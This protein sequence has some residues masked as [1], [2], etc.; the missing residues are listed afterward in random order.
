MQSLLDLGI[1]LL[2]CAV[3]SLIS[4]RLRL[5]TLSG[6][7]MSFLIGV[8]IGYFGSINWLIILIAFALSGFVVTKFKFEL[9]KKK[10]VQEG[11]KGERT[12][13]NVVA[14]S[15][16]P[17]LIAVG[18]WLLGQQGSAA[19]NL[20]YL[21]SVSV[22]ASDTIA[23]ELGVLSNRTFLIT[24]MRRVPVGTD[25][26][27]SA[28]GTIWAF[29]GAAFASSLGWLLLFP[30]GALDARLLIPIVMGFV[31]CNIDSLIGATLERKG[32]TSKLSTNLLSM[33]FASLGAL[34]IVWAFY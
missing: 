25:G 13:K 8:V 1:I 3:L 27:V 19:A 16:I 17:V 31:G 10:G 29:I 26:G 24:N 7:L 12:W 28:Y 32:I 14:N 2:L 5:L 33:A 15:L 34:L 20:I 6:S 4:Y 21:T 22:A 18:A 11:K 23:S 30:W 9:K